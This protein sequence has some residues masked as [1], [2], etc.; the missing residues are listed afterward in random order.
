MQG[1]LLT[2]S[3]EAALTE[4]RAL[5]EKFGDSRSGEAAAALRLEA[6]AKLGS[7]Q[8]ELDATLSASPK[9]MVLRSVG[10]GLLD[11][12]DPR[13]Q[14]L[15]GEIDGLISQIKDVQDRFHAAEALYAAKQ[16]SR[17]ADLYEGLH[18]TDKDD[19]A[20]RRHLTALHFADRRLEARQLFDSLN[21]QIKGY[22]NTPKPEQ[23]SMSEQDYL[24]NAESSSNGHYFA[25]KTFR[26]GF[27]G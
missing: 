7:L 20:L 6:A 1:L 5:Q 8:A 13:R 25:R 27:N 18:G 3:A 23:P 4:A 21:D 14:T 22:H 10:V 24:P 16:Y 19:I 26:G 12:A 11:E 9:S 17:A 2:G 15:L